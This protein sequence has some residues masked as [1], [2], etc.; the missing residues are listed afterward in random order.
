MTADGRRARVRLVG[1]HRLQVDADAGPAPSLGGYGD[2]LAAAPYSFAAAGLKAA[3]DAA[4]EARGCEVEILDLVDAARDAD[5][6][7]PREEFRLGDEHLAQLAAGDPDA[8]CFSAYCWNVDAALAACARLKQRRPETLT[9]LGGRAV[10]DVGPALLRDY[11]AVDHVVQGEAERSFVEL[12]GRWRA[13]APRDRD[14]PAGVLGRGA[15]GEIVSGPAAAPIAALDALP[16]P[17]LTGVA[18]PPPEGMMLELSRGCVN[19]CGYCAWSSAKER[20][21]FSQERIA[22]ELRWALQH[23]VRHVTL[24]DSAINYEPGT[25]AR[26]VAAATL[27]DPGREL[28]YTYN[29]RHELVTPEQVALLARLRAQ[30]VLLGMESLTEAAMRES[31]RQPLD[32]A[33]F[34]AALRLLRRLSPDGGTPATVV[35]VVLGLPGDTLDGFRRTMDYLGELSTEPAGSPIGAVLVSLLQVFPGTTLWRRREALGVK[36]P[37]RGIPYVRGVGTFPRADLQRALSYV[38]RLRVRYPLFV[39]RPEGAHTLLEPRAPG[40]ADDL[41]RL[42]Q[43]WAPGAFRAGWLL[44]ALTPLLD[45][46]GIAV[47]TF[48]QPAARALVRVRLDRRTAARAG[49]AQTERFN[50]YH[51]GEVPRS[52]LGPSLDALMREVVGL[53]RRN[54]G[55][56]A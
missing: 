21:T 45:G 50:V 25:V 23:D 4:P 40:P 7:A 48:A 5:G 39:K 49:F 52:L 29:L 53:L 16:S 33:R 6:A 55:S 8:V 56:W 28:R 31:D 13:G 26:F 35:G 15:S 1:L 36:L 54:E 12:L 20:R 10:E 43:P 41:R 18:H 9:V 37:D 51:Q 44:R 42:L 3:A 11:P 2:A 46:D 19:R 47:L 38:N 22:D 32:C 14:L 34:E 17:Y 30:Q 27:A 24:L